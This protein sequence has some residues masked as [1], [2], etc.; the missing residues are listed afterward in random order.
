MSKALLSPLHAGSSIILG[1]LPGKKDSRE[2]YAPEPIDPLEQQ[3]AGYALAEALLP[4]V[5]RLAE[6]LIS[7][8]DDLNGVDWEALVGRKTHPNARMDAIQNIQRHVRD[9]LHRFSRKPSQ[10]VWQ[11][12]EEMKPVNQV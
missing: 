1:L 3:D 8:P 11:V 2:H 7:G 4:V 6:L 12:N 9:V 10:L 5:H